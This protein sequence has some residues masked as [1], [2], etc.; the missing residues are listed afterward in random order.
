MPA[1]L[2]NSS[3]VMLLSLLCFA[4]SAMGLTVHDSDRDKKKCRDC[5]VAAVEGGSAGLY[6]LL[7]GATCLG[8]LRFRS[9]QQAQNV[10]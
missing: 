4:P 8:A 5:K 6:L 9:R 7:A 3:F 10:K 1:K 2:R